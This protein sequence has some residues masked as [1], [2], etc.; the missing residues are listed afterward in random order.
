MVVNL[1]I[2][3]TSGLPRKSNFVTREPEQAGASRRTEEIQPLAFAVWL[4]R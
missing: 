1:D 3:A 4:I 2:Q